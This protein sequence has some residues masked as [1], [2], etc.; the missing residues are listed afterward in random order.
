VGPHQHGDR[1]GRPRFQSH[2]RQS[3]HPADVHIQIRAV[4][5]ARWQLHERRPVESRPVIAA[6][7]RAAYIHVPFCRHRWGYCDFTL[8]AGR[9]DLI[10]RYLACLERELT[11][12]PSKKLKTLF[13]GGGTPTHPPMEQL[14]RLLELTQKHLPM[15]NEAEI[16][17]EANPLDLTDE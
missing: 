2:R 9:D 4:H 12:A 15:A 6:P 11:T 13:F 16:S 3:H 5:A 1:H 8:V 7:P 17:I 10:E 14:R